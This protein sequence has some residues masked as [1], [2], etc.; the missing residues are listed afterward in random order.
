[1]LQ[2][3]TAGIRAPA[4][5][6]S[7]VFIRE[8]EPGLTFSRTNYWVAGDVIGTNGNGWWV[9]DVQRHG[10]LTGALTVQCQ[11][12]AGTAVA[13]QDFTPTN[14][15][16]LFQPQQFEIQVIAPVLRNEAAVE[17]RTLF[18]VLN[19]PAPDISL[20]TD[21]TAMLTLWGKPRIPSL[22]AGASAL[23]TNGCM[24][25]QCDTRPGQY[26]EVETSTDLVNWIYLRYAWPGPNAWP[27]I[28]EDP[29]A[30]KYPQRFYRIPLYQS[31]D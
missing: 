12:V 22:I 28:I 6:T 1:H 5:S 13:G 31:D 7:I 20:A 17:D 21:A 30:W 16:L 8:T 18:L 24:R 11:L 29:E 19:H 15:T 10:D 2:D 9:A 27:V 26:L 25:L 14:F 23:D 4:G 3:R